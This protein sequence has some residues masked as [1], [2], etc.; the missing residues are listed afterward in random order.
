MDTCI[1]S[2]YG[3]NVFIFQ[4]YYNVGYRFLHI[5]LLVLFIMPFCLFLASSG[6]FR[7]L[8]KDN[9]NKGKPFA[10][11]LLYYL[12]GRMLLNSSKFK[13]GKLTDQF[14]ISLEMIMLFPP[15]VYLYTVFH[16]CLFTYFGPLLCASKKH[17]L[18]MLHIF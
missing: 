10:E 12:S 5:D 13:D 7:W 17:K 1:I 9:I 14:S 8:V 16:F 11:Y 18:I 4:I 2:D 6:I 15:S 3:W